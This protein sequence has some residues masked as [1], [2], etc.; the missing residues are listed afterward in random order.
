MGDVEFTANSAGFK[1]L[2]CSSEMKACLRGFAQEMADRAN[3]MA[4]PEDAY[5][6]EFEVPPYAAG[7]HMMPNTALGTAYAATR[8][9]EI[10]EANAH[11]LAAQ[12]H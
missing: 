11:L 5:V 12:N 2:C 3:W 9:G 4:D 10:C 1:E 8:V 7:I 6:E